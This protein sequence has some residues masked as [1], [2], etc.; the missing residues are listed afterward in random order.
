VERAD[1]FDVQMR[2]HRYHES[3]FEDIPRQ[4]VLDMIGWCRQHDG[5][6]RYHVN[7]YP[8]EDIPDTLVPD[9]RTGSFWFDHAEDR[10]LFELTWR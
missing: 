10:M 2:P 7:F 1:A 5:S 3:R 9:P 6:G 8:H 4:Q